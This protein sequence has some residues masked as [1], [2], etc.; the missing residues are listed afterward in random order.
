MCQLG[1]GSSTAQKMRFSIKDFFGKCDQSR[2][3]LQIW[4]Q[5]L[6]KSL[7]ENFIFCAVKIFKLGDVIVMQIAKHEYPRIFKQCWYLKTLVR[8]QLVIAC[9][10]DRA[11]NLFLTN[12]WRN[13]FLFVEPFSITLTRFVC[14]WLALMSRLKYGLFWPGGYYR[15]SEKI[16]PGNSIS[17]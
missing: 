3:K 14:E 17:P 7:M 8:F 9:K 10:L 11:F 4:S 15:V 13:K 5:L 6:K 2:R 12:F 16:Q 1:L